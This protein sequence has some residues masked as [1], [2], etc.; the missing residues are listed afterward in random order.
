VVNT[1]RD[2][3]LLDPNNSASQSQTI[4]SMGGI[5]NKAGNSSDPLSKTMA[6]GV[7]PFAKFRFDFDKDIRGVKSGV[8]KAGAEDESGV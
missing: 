6:A 2:A 4:A 3:L 7:D 8:K 1:E 5:D